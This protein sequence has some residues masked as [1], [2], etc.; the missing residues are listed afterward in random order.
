MFVPSRAH[1]AAHFPS[2]ASRVLVAIK[3]MIFGLGASSYL[4]GVS[5]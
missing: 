1:L 2:R 4:L 3:R 5:T